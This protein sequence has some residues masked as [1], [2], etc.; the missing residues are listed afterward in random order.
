VALLNLATD[1]GRTYRSLG[2]MQAGYRFAALEGLKAQ[3]N[4]DYD[5]I[6]TD[7]QNFYPSTLHGQTKSGNL[8]S[9][10]R[11]NQSQSNTALETYLNYSAGLRVIPGTIDATGGYS[12]G[13]SHAEYPSYS[14][15]ALHHL[16]GATASPRAGRWSIP[17]HPGEP[18]DLGVRAGQLQSQRQVPAGGERAAGRL[19]RFRA[20]QPVGHLPVAS[21]GWRISEE[22]FLKG[23]HSSRTS[24]SGLL[25]Q[26]RQPGVRE[27]SAV[28]RVPAGNDQAQ[29]SS[30]TSTCRRSGPARTTSLKWEATNVLST[31]AS[32]SHS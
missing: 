22:P 12:Y 25:G 7:R 31:W 3:V 13:W 14:A 27:L 4:L 32:T 20:H 23:Q 10:F 29:T 6:R 21:V 26:D 2:S 28:R 11:A 1:H 16:L 17:G 30:A 15:T 18:A 5:I 19:V 24:S 9:D 8:G